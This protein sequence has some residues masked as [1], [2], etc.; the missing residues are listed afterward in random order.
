MPARSA[1][2]T[3]PKP[4]RCTG[5]VIPDRLGGLPGAFPRPRPFG[6][7]NVTRAS[8]RCSN[9][10]SEDVFM[11]VAKGVLPESEKLVGTVSVKATMLAAHLDW[12][13][14]HSGVAKAALSGLSPIATALVQSS[15]LATDW[16]PFARLIEIDKAIA[17]TAGGSPAYVY[18]CLGRHSAMLN[19]KGAY[20]SFVRDE[21]HRFFEQCALLH[22]RFQDFGTSR[23]ERTG[24]Q[25]GRLILEEYPEYS[26][27]FCASGVGY[28]LA[29]VEVMGAPGHVEGTE[30]LCQCNG[31]P[32][33]VFDVS[34]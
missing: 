26:P 33:C 34:W 18:R 3:A 13:Q 19:L 16:I 23:Y 24:L 9:I 32:S 8:W 11:N 31:D 25:S 22:R 17:A 6:V 28:Y 21:P 7:E 12:L 1:D 20:K 2:G 5:S 14:H 29:A 4:H 10:S 15:L 30:S 27:V